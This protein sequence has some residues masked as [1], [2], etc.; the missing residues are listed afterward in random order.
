MG[1]YRRTKEIESRIEDLERDVNEV[2]NSGEKVED[3]YARKIHGG[4]IFVGSF[5]EPDTQILLQS[6]PVM[7][8]K[9]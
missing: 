8:Y 4:L 5:A 9:S 3:C 7:C 6:A 1:S 2:E